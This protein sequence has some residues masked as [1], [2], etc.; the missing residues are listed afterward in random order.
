VPWLPMPPEYGELT[1][2]EQLEDTA[3]TLSLVRRAV[4]LRRRH[5]GFTGTELEWFGAPVGCLAFRRAGTTLVCALN[6]S[7]QAVA[8][9]PGDV[10]LTS[11][12]LD[13]GLLPPDTAAWLA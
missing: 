8:L 9:P 3:S 12:P 6:T 11:G 13:D 5:P 10:L 1:V 2:A 4:E 7:D